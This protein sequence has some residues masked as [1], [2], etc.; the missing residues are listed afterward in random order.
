MS[1]PAPVSDHECHEYAELEDAEYGD[2]TD[3]LE[4]IQWWRCTFCGDLWKQILC[5]GFTE[6][7]D[8]IVYDNHHPREWPALPV[9]DIFADVI[10]ARERADGTHTC[11]DHLLIEWQ[12]YL[13]TIGDRY[14][15][16]CFV[17]GSRGLVIWPDA[18]PLP[19]APPY[20]LRRPA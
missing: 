12:A 16:L 13:P 17:C 8:S 3:R 6:L 1:I 4:E 5:S 14:Y 18:D 20:P 15:L 9:V 10:A 7:A 19:P 2:R 11:R